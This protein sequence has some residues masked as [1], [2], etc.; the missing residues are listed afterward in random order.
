MRPLQAAAEL[1][2]LTGK[3]NLADFL[4][5]PRDAPPAALLRALDQRKR[6]LQ[7]M[8]TNPKY[9]LQAA[10]VLRHA[11]ALREVCEDPE[12]HFQEMVEQAEQRHLPA[13]ERMLQ[14]LYTAGP[15]APRRLDELRRGASE[16][17]V[18]GESFDRVLASVEQRTMTAHRPRP[19]RTKA[20]TPRP[21]RPEPLAEGGRAP[22]G[23]SL[24]AT[25]Q[26]RLRDA[27]SD[28]ERQRLAI[29]RRVL[30]H[31]AA[32]ERYEVMLATPS[33]G[34]PPSTNRG[35]ATPEGSIVFVSGALVR[36]I[37][38]RRPDEVT[39]VVSGDSAG[40]ATVTCDV[41]W[42]TA[43]PSA[44][45]LV[46][47]THTIV[48]AVLRDELPWTARSGAVSVRSRESELQVEYRLPHFLYRMVDDVTTTVRR[49]ARRFEET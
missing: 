31:P 30:A 9:R 39:V 47:G 13:I 20:P 3:A 33:V 4:G 21:R 40:T 43:H 22:R 19:R 5:Q 2:R 18:R 6:W 17:G 45:Q 48:V 8:L 7:S 23:E 1:C 49:V 12:P 36:E 42:L 37:P 38:R 14:G 29:A 26:R 25:Y 41:P 16:L 35:S 15:I 27:T 28:A 34:G 11:A 10:F 44:L 46:A 32:R 24:D